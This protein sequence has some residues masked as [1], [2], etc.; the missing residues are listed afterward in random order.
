[1]ASQ[2]LKPSLSANP[3]SMNLHNFFHMIGDFLVF[4]NPP[5]SIFV[6][7]NFLRLKLVFFVVV[8]CNPNPI[9]A[10]SLDSA[11]VDNLKTQLAAIQSQL[12]SL[13]ERQNPLDSNSPGERVKVVGS[14]RKKQVI[15][16]QPIDE[17]TIQLYDLSDLFAVSPHYPAVV[18]DDFAST[19]DRFRTQQGQMIGGGLGGG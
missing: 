2:M 7:R 16:S 1:M 3:N 13:E 5:A 18:P 14:Q 9:W 12:S 10:Q 6:L 17:L 8:V 19:T 15:Q 4:K 11:N